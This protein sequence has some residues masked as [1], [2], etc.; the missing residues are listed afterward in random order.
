MRFHPGPLLPSGRQLLGHEVPSTSSCT[1]IQGSMRTGDGAYWN[2]AYPKNTT[3][4]EGWELLF[5]QHESRRPQSP[6]HASSRT[7]VLQGS[8]RGFKTVEEERSMAFGLGFQNLERFSRGLLFHGCPNWKRTKMS[9][10]PEAAYSREPSPIKSPMSLVKSS[11]KA[12]L[13]CEAISF[14][15]RPST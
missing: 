12:L 6:P 11:T 4:I 8:Q 7:R 10:S 13:G 1:S 15:A 5:C 3:Q 14:S 2:N 9:V